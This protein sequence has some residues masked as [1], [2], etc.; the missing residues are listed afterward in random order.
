MKDEYEMAAE[1][2]TKE[3]IKGI[4]D[5]GGKTADRYTVVFD[6]EIR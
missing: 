2:E 3:K 1:A 6:G 5:N 4:Y